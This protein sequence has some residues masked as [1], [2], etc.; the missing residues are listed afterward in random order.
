MKAH[1]TEKLIAGLRPRERDYYVWDVVSS[2]GEGVPGLAVRVLPSGAKV[3]TFQFRVRG[4]AGAR[5]ENRKRRVSLGPW[6]RSGAGCRSLAEARRQAGEWWMRARQGEDP[7]APRRRAS[8]QT[9]AELRDNY[10][11]YLQSRRKPRTYDTARRNL[12]KHVPTDWWA[13]PVDDISFEEI[14]HLHAT[15]GR[16]TRGMANRLVALLH[17]MF[18]RARIK[19]R[20][21]LPMG[22]PCAAVEKLGEPGRHRALTD[23][24][25]RR[26]SEVL[27]R[28]LAS[29]EMAWQYPALVRLLLLTGAR[30]SEV[31]PLRWGPL[32]GE[33]KRRR[34]EQRV[35]ADL[36]AKKAETLQGDWSDRYLDLQPDPW[37]VLDGDHGHIVIEHHKTDG[38]IGRKKIYLCPAAVQHLLLLPSFGNCDWVFPSPRNLAVPLV[39]PQKRWDEIRDLAGLGPTDEVSAFRL[40]DARHSLVSIGKR[41][42]VALDDMAP[43]LGHTSKEMTAH[44]LTEDEDQLRARMDQIGEIIRR[45]M[46]GELRQ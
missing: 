10:L 24:E 18:E 22:N 12:E 28:L 35:R 13:R 11:A 39:S 45:A 40:H 19:L 17:A 29:G 1:L 42:G 23:V 33:A 31:L 2:T 38:V 43:L 8:V 3:F 26:L 34:W 37:V 5:S 6:G 9:L 14:E 30:K 21:A 16:R 36:H 25:Y 27:D 4:S 20:W 15:L 46:A 41:N 32:H 44:Y 7:A